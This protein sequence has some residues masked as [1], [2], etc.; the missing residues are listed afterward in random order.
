MR[1]LYR[2]TGATKIDFVGRRIA[3]FGFTALIFIATIVSLFTQGLNLGI[4]FRGGTL[5]EIR[6]AEPI[7]IGS[8]RAQMAS[9]NLGEVQV[10][11]L[12][13]PRTALIRVQRQETETGTQTVAATAIQN[14]LADTVEYRRVDIVGP[15][16][17]GETLRTGLIA[18]GLAILLIAIYVWFR[19]EW[20][21]GVSALFATGHD[22]ITTIGLFSIFQI[23]FNV[24]AVAAILTLAGYSINDTVIVFDRVRENLRKHKKMPLDQL[25]NLSTNETLSRTIITSGTTLTA[26]LALLIFGA[27]STYNFCIAMAWGILIG[28]FSSIYVASALLLYMKP[29]RREDPNQQGDLAV[30]SR[31]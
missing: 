30:V 17:S 25:L 11:L 4:D 8:L 26:V 12:D 7:D 6:A 20:Q 14:L 9:L 16:I 31:P 15:T 10:T 29:L 21:F 18:S 28:T 19:F 2:F 24:A 27:E 1:G 22:V 3:A 13:D 5:V 23:E